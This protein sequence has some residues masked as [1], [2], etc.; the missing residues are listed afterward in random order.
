MITSIIFLVLA[1]LFTFLGVLKGKKY[2]WVFSAARIVGAVLAAVL[3]MLLSVLAARLLGSLCAGAFDQGDMARLLKELPSMRFALEALV[4]MI[5][6]PI[7]FWP[8]FPIVYNLLNILLKWVSRVIVKAMPQ[9]ISGVGEPVVKESETPKKRIRNAHL[10]ATGANPAGMILGG[11]CGLLLFCIALV[12]L[13]GM[14]GVVQDVAEAAVAV[15]KMENDLPDEAMTSLDKSA[16]NVCFV[17]VRTLG[18]KALYNGLTTYWAG[19]DT[20]HLNHEMAVI[21][22]FGSAMTSYADKDVPRA[23]AAVAVRALEPAMAEATLIP[24]VGAEFVSVASDRWAQGE[25]F[26]DIEMPSPEGYESLMKT[27]VS[28]QKGATKETFREDAGTVIR[29]VAQLV[30]KDAMGQIQGDAMALLGNQ[31]LTEDLLYEL[32]ENPRLYVTVGSAL[33]LGVEKIGDNLQMHPSRARLYHEL[34][35]EVHAVP[36]LYNVK[37]EE[38]CRRTAADYRKVM[39]SYGIATE[40]NEVYDRAALASA[41]G[42][43]DMV[44]WFADED[45]VTSQTMLQKTELVTTEELAIEPIN[46]QNKTEEAKKLSEALATMDSVSEKA[47][48]DDMDVADFIADFG[49]ALDALSQT[50]TVGREKSGK[51]FKATL[52]SKKVSEKIGFSMLEASNAA[53]TININAQRSSYVIQMISLSQTVRVIRNAGTAEGEAAIEALIKDLTPESASTL[54]TLSTPS[55]MMNHGVPEKSSEPVSDMMSDMF[56]NLS[57]AKEAGN[58]SDEQLQRET[59]AVNKV[60]TMG[61]NAG[62]ANGKAFG[63]GSV[64]GTSADQ[65]VSDIMNSDVVSQTV[66]EQVYTNGSDPKND[67]LR[68]DRTMTATEEAELLTALNDQWTNATDE[69]RGDETYQKKLIS[70]AALMNM[71]VTVGN[72]GVSKV[73]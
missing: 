33:D 2:T 36:R 30:E 50:E 16:N 12:P 23:E 41:T 4:A 28:T 11:V 49:P 24:K 45:V 3:A 10:R 60:M 56:G 39:E 48:D 40:D 31:E 66:V 25:D 6:S 62:D 57:D 18:G 29:M 35:K 55:V 22:A 52:Q 5:I 51:I 61:M 38:A 14:T 46:V 43:T 1:A 67:P 71:E 26:H 72:G 54:Q 15:S 68:T 59:V 27:I 37:D 65:F 58:M 13:V 32:L 63:E 7:L 34:C 19:E 44:K 8:I 20:V 73:A 21:D 53:D 64:T 42:S 17:A 70:I 9:K 69:Q 47:S